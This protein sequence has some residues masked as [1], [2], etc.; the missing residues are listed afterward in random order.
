MSA[1]SVTGVSG[2][3]SASQPGVGN[4]GSDNMSLAVH[5]LI[6]PRVVM[7]GN[8]TLDDDGH[9]IVD[10]ATL[11]GVVGDYGITLTKAD[12]STTPYYGG[13]TTSRFGIT[14]GA[15]QDVTWTV[16]KTGRWGSSINPMGNT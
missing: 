16:V 14:G 2:P 12:S 7:A 6:G 15:N 5:R 10:Y 9:G 13:F 4:K 11:P 3:G 1:T 8:I